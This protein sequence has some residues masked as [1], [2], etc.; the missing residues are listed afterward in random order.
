V[1]LIAH[2]GASGHAPENTMAAFKLALELGAKAVELDIHQTK[3]RELAVIHD[4]D[5]KRVGRR[6][7]SVKSL[8]MKELADVDVG[9]WFDK[10]FKSEGVPPLEEVLDL[11]DGKAVVHVE[12]KKGSSLYHGIE[13]QVVDLIQRRKAHEAIVV[14]S[15]DHDALYRVRSIDSKVR[16][17]YLRGLATMRTSFRELKELKAESLHMSLRQLDARVVRE[18]HHHGFKLNIYTVNAP[19]DVA[20]LAKMGV[21][22]IFCN[23]PELAP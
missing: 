13:E 17:G 7:A 6:K 1:Q 5:L 2:R 4:F 3:D 11:C 18:T 10:R 23:F 14:S 15:F 20:R 21:D 19:K 9:S 8:A 12:L 22:G 16:I